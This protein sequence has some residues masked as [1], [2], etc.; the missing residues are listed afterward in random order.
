MLNGLLFAGL[1]G[2]A[3]AL[4]QNIGIDIE[5]VVAAGSPTVSGAPLAATATQAVPTYDASVAA[6]AASA[7]AAVNPVVTS[8]SDKVKRDTA[9][10]PLPK[11]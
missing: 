6:E 10:S 9:C 3:A 5:A 2:V 11:G 4:P 8:T 7:D 1:A